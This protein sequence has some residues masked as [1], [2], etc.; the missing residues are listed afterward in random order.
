[1]GPP[2]RLWGKSILVLCKSDFS[3]RRIK[4]LASWFLLR[5]GLGSSILLRVQPPAVGLCRVGGFWKSGA[6][7]PG[8]LLCRAGVIQCHPAFQTLASLPRD[9]WGLLQVARPW[10]HPW[11]EQI[12]PYALYLLTQLLHSDYQPLQAWQ[13]HGESWGRCLARCPLLYFVFSAHPSF[14]L[15]WKI[16]REDFFLSSPGSFLLFCFLKPYL[17]SMAKPMWLI[18]S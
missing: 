12:F 11:S 6:H 17:G 13:Q 5:W 4:A 3:V 14:W 1:M 9:L 18:S 7:I 8:Q 15:K 16:F 10:Q 2:E